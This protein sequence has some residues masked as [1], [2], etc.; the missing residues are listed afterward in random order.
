MNVGNDADDEEDFADEY[1]VTPAMLDGLLE[2][3]RTLS[4]SESAAGKY[5]KHYDSYGTL[6]LIENA[7]PSPEIPLGGTSHTP[8]SDT[9]RSALP[10]LEQLREASMFSQIRKSAQINTYIHGSQLWKGLFFSLSESFDVD[11]E[12]DSDDGELDSDDGEDIPG[13]RDVGRTPV[14]S[15]KGV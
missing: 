6:L 3:E 11:E 5:L 8:A 1:I 4:L 9:R 10:S 7:G 2:L 12:T 13:L 15:T 14:E